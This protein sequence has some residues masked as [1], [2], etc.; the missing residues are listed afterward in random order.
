MP[1]DDADKKHIADSI[2]EAFKGDA[3]KTALAPAIADT[4]K[5]EITG[6]ISGLKLDE[7]I[8]AKVGEATKGLKPPDTDGKGGDGKGGDDK[9]DPAVAQLRAQ[10][11]EL[12]RKTKVAEQAAASE[13][14]AREEEQ[15]IGALRETLAKAGVPAEKQRPVVALLHAADKRVR[16]TTDG[17][18][19]LHFRRNGYEEVLPLEAAVKEWLGTDEGKQFLPPTG[20]Q[21]TGQGP[22]NRTP[23]LRTGGKFDP[24]KAGAALFAA[25][26]A[27]A[28]HTG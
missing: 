27:P 28:A 18:P 26:R 3:L 13:K 4:V 6:A 5:R 1:L 15:L 14:A 16:R 7:T 23:D 17:Q 11:E 20:V 22:G 8:A 10:L 9:A 12:T 25:T 24:D 2:A 19:G 21:G